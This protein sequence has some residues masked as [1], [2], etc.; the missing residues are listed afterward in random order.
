M[1]KQKFQEVKE[2]MRNLLRISNDSDITKNNKDK[3]DNLIILTAAE[4]IE[5]AHEG[6]DFKSEMPCNCAKCDK[7]EFYKQVHYLATSMS[8]DLM[9]SLD[10]IIASK[11]NP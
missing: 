11:K 6:E 10:T 3:I 9:T 7:D 2:D 8:E 4:L 5:V 1:N